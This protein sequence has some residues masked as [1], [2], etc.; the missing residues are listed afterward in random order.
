MAV[1]CAISSSDFSGGLTA[2]LLAEEPSASDE[3]SE[4]AGAAELSEVVFDGVELPL[5]LLFE[6]S[7][8]AA[9]EE[10]PGADA[11]SP[12]SSSG[13]VVKDEVEDYFDC[14]LLEVEVEAACCVDY[15]YYGLAESPSVVLGDAFISWVEVSDPSPDYA[16]PD[17]SS[18]ASSLLSSE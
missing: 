2:S 18:S 4:S 15:C 8:G 3:V 17:P 10:S 6:L 14:W 1:S 7:A 13:A 16:S 12:S 9:A 5:V 11:S